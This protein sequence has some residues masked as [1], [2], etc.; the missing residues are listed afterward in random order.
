MPVTIAD[1]L[2][3]PALHGASLLTDASGLDHTITA[4]SVLEYSDVTDTQQDL[5]DQIRYQGNELVLTAFADTIQVVDVEE[6][7]LQIC[8]R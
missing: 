4:V 2:H 5:V 8:P 7:P 6:T 3:L 1:A